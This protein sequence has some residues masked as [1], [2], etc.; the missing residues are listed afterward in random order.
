MSDNPQGQ[1]WW[2]A[3]DG[4]WYPPDQPPGPGWWKASDGNWYPPQGQTTPAAPAGVAPA[5]DQ[6]V[7]QPGAGQP[8]AGQPGAPQPGAGQPGAGQPGAGQPGAGQPGGTQ[9]IPAPS[10]PSPAPGPTPERSGGRGKGLVI[11]GIVVVVILLAGA[12]VFLARRGSTTVESGGSASTQGGGGSGSGGGG[13]GGGDQSAGGGPDEMPRGDITLADGVV[14]V[15]G[16]GGKTIKSFS[17][18]GKTIVLDSGADGIDKLS[19][20]KVMLLTGV[21]AVKVASLEKSGDGV[22]IT[23]EPATLPDVIK[24]GELV[25]D[26]QVDASQGKF[27]LIESG[28]GDSTGGSSGGGSSGGGSSGGSP[29]APGSGDDSGIGSGENGPDINNPL[30]GGAGRPAFGLGESAAGLVMNAPGKTISGKVGPL[31]GEIT[32]DPVSN[33]AKLNVKLTSSADVS[34]TMTIDATIRSLNYKGNAKVTNGQTQEF[35]FNMDDLS[36]SAVIETDLQ[37]LQN[38]A[39]IK[40]PPFFK[41]PF[42]VDFPALVG[43]IPFTLSLSGSIQVNLSM[44]LANASLKGRAEVSFSGDAGFNFRGGSVSLNGNRVQ[45]A[46]DLLKTIQGLSGGPVGVVVTTELPKVGFGF[47]FLQTGAQIYISNG[48]VAS[49]TVLPAPAQCTAMNVAYVLAGGVEAKFLGKGFDIARKSFVKKEWNYQAPT[50]K[51][52]NAPK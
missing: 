16:N 28:T 33:G 27:H 51:R 23:T 38:V 36:G 41:L 40:I 4:K 39:T 52:C 48:M 17:T 29:G 31:D 30:G 47:S 1:G 26:N 34:G 15:K 18:D 13:G 43:G 11:A 45:D 35:N 2:Q 32:Y 25:W 7:A 19:E 42:S 46:P 3:A 20:G 5:A 37:G 49:Q 10:G 14:V 21:T 24:D 9:A 44:A 22:T 12:G 8:G 50:D 6:A